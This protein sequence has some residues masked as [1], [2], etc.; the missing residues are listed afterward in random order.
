MLIFWLA[1]VAMATYQGVKL[2]KEFAKEG[3][4]RESTILT[5]TGDTLKL[6][7]SPNKTEWNEK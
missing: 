1:G 6:D 3:I 4:N 5:V 2:G 7:V